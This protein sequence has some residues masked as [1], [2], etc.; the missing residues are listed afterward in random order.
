MWSVETTSEIIKLGGSAA[1]LLAT[2]YKG[3]QWFLRTREGRIVRQMYEDEH[4]RAD[5][6]RTR[7]VEMTEELDRCRQE[8]GACR[9]AH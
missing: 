3:G 5:Y 7:S 9:D 2:V 6:Y 8:L 4:T 1:A